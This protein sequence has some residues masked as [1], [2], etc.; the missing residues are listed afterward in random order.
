MNEQKERAVQLL[1]EASTILF[2]MQRDMI[3][4]ESGYVV[5]LP[6]PKDRL[7]DAVA[8]IDQVIDD[9]KDLDL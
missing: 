3:D 1:G 2:D 9:L 7:L 8:A 5:S 6:T 4:D